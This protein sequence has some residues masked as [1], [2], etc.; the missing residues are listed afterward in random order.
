MRTTSS[1]GF[2]MFVHLVTRTM[3]AH[4]NGSDGG[5]HS[6]G[7]DNEIPLAAATTITTGKQNYHQNHMLN[8]AAPK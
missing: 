2:N 3:C 6:Y 4:V 1:D 5:D 8:T 7:G